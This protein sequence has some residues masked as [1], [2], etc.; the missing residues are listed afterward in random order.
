M[1]ADGK[2]A[3]SPVAIRPRRFFGTKPPAVATLKADPIRLG[4]RAVIERQPSLRDGARCSQSVIDRRF[5]RADNLLDDAQ[6]ESDAD[7]ELK[8]HKAIRSLMLM[9]HQ[10]RAQPRRARGT[11]GATGHSRGQSMR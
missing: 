3:A 5:G 1:V 6:A 10:E 4:R 8:R 11:I 2:A 7:Q 9:V